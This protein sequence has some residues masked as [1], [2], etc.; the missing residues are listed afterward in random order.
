M[1]NNF[2]IKM[3]DKM[4][5]DEEV[6]EDYSNLEYNKEKLYIGLDS[7][8]EQFDINKIEILRRKIILIYNNFSNFSK[9]V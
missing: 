3:D 5:I 2:E 4:D 8:V 6:Q 7:L 9:V 1:E